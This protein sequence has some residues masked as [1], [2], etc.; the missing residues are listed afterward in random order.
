MGQVSQKALIR[1]GGRV[2]L[3]RYSQSSPVHDSRAWGT[4]D[5][6]GGR[7]NTGENVVEGVKRE[8]REE[9]GVDVV[10]GGILSTGTFV[11][12]NGGTNFFVIYEARLVSDDAVFVPEEAE[13]AEIQWVDE[14]EALTLPF[15]Y[16]EYLIALRGIL[17]NV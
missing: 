8:V 10:I 4:W 1:Q 3:V 14:K 5:M 12:F 7:L 2:L 9:I 16:Q 11:K 17:E 6:P 15:I 13:V